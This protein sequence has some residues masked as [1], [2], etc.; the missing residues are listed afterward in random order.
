M[1]MHA[2]PSLRTHCSMRAFWLH[3]WQNCLAGR[4]EHRG[5]SCVTPAQ[6]KLSV[7]EVRAAL[8]RLVP[9]TGLNSVP[10]ARQQAA[11]E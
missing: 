2:R 10:V 5:S 11:V 6:A 8:L 9:G 1:H 7:L 4:A 3:I